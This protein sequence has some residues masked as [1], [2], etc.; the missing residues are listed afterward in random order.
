MLK[1]LAALLVTLSAASAA[2][3]APFH[4]TSTPQSA[5]V[6]NGATGTMR[7]KDGKIH[8][9]MAV[10]I[11]N[12]HS[13]GEHHAFVWYPASAKA[14]QGEGG[15]W[16]GMTL[17]VKHEIGGLRIYEGE[18]KDGEHNF[19]SAT[20]Y[21]SGVAFGLLGQKPSAAHPGFALWAQRIGSNVTPQ[22]APR[23]QDIA[24]LKQMHL[25]P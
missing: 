14:A 8:V 22:L 2:Q 23:P 4:I 17:K 12:I 1:T 9:T 13:S 19:D 11:A 5:G 16:Q 15:S 18:F 20:A 24:F 3:A 6:V 10:P 25:I 21:R 7:V